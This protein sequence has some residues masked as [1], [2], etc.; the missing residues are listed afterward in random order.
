MENLGDIS[1]P[2]GAPIWNEVNHPVN[3]PIATRA[4]RW[5]YEFMEFSV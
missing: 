1:E 4:E 2:Q 3:F 5:K